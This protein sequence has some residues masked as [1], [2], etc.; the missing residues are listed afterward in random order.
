MAHA[1][2]QNRGQ[3]VAGSFL[4]ASK[5]GGGFEPAKKLGDRHSLST[6]RGDYLDDSRLR[7]LG[8]AEPVTKFFSRYCTDIKTVW[9]SATFDKILIVKAPAARSA[10]SR[11]WI[12]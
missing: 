5:P 6:R 12:W 8:T 3:E 1:H 4:T 7:R 10:G 2:R 9:L 11:R